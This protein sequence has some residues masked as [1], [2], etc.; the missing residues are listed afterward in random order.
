[1]IFVSEDIPSKLVSK[2]TLPDDI[3][4]I[5][6][7]INLRQTKWLIL[8]TYHPPNQTDYYFFKSVGN[9]LDQYLKTYEKFL[10]LGDF[11]AED[12]EPILSEFLEQYEAKNIMKNKTCFENSDRPTCIDLFLTNSPH[13]FQNTIAI[14]TGFSDFHKMII[15]VLK[16]SFIKLKAREIYY[17]D[18]KNFSSNPFREDLT[19]SLDRINKGFDSFEYTFMKT[20]NRHAPMKKKFVRANEVPYMTKALRKAIMKRSE[21]ESKYLKNKSYQNMKIYQKIKNFAANYIRRKE[22]NFLRKLIHIN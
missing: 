15:T 2:H 22:K 3:E 4:G 11:N 7:E 13:S 8:E 18:Y 20:C 1:M 12:T 17:R 21:L 10:L 5:F 6:I 16:S 14:S 9:T 19:L